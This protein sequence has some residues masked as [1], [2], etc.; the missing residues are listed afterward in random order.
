MSGS[1]WSRF[2]TAMEARFVKAFAGD[3]PP[4]SM[5][6]DAESVGLSWVG[7]ERLPAVVGFMAELIGRLHDLKELPC[8]SLVEEEGAEQRLI[9]FSDVTAFAASLAEWLAIPC[10]DRLRLE[11]TPGGISMAV[12]FEGTASS[13]M[14][15][16]FLDATPVPEMIQGLFAKL[17][18]EA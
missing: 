6:L 13:G 4:L 7:A 14:M 17:S 9:D 10:H 1:K 2:L 18:E 5:E 16:L 3:V 15:V 11:A 12:R 8:L